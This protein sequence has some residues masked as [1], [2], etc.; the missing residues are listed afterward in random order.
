M[1]EIGIEYDPSSW[2]LFI[3]SSTDS[4]KAVL[5]HNKNIIPSV[6][7]KNYIQMKEYYEDID[8]YIY[9]YLLNMIN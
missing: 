3:D 7:V 1:K 2:R 4:L 5:L 9:I 8:I 6:P